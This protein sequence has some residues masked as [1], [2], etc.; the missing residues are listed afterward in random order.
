MRADLHVHCKYSSKSADQVLKK[1]G[2]QESYTEVEEVYRTAKSNGMDLVTITD[3]NAI[4]G[5]LEL[6]RH[7]P[8]DCFLGV[9]ITTCFPE[10]GCAVHV[11]VYDFTEEQFTHMDRIRGDIYELRDYIRR[12]GL[13]YSV[14][15]ATYSVNGKLSLS[16]IEKLILLF[17][18]FET[19]NGTRVATYND[20]L[21]KVLLGL[22]PEKIGELRDRHG[23][24]PFS[25]TPWIKGF[26]GG[27]DEHAGLFIGETFTSG[28]ASTKE[29]FLRALR[30]GRT[31]SG[32]RSNDYRTQVYTFLK[33]AYHF[34]RTKKARGMRQVWN[35]ICGAIFEG[36][37]LNWKTQLKIEHLK[38]SRRGKTRIIASQA[39]R[40]IKRLVQDPPL[41]HREK[42][43]LIYTTVAGFE[44]DLFIANFDGF[45]EAF[46]RADIMK[47]FSSLT[48]AFRA[49]F[50]SLP[51][52]GTFRHLHQS[53]R[54]MDEF[55]QAFLGPRA[56]G[57]KKVLWFTDTFGDLNGVSV[58]LD[59]VVAR[60]AREGIRVRLAVTER[61][62]LSPAPHL[63]GLPTVYE[64]VPEFYPDYC[65]R[66][67]SLLK[68]LERISVEAPSEIIV[69]TPGPV[70]L[71]GL[72]ASRLF[73]IPC[74]G[75]YHS[76][77][78]RMTELSLSGGSFASLVQGYTRWF[79]GAVDEVLVPTHEM[80][81]ALV[82]RGYDR[83]RM[84]IFPRTIDLELFSPVP[85]ER[86]ALRRDWGLEEGMTLLYVGRVS[87]DK[88]LGV[89][90]E[91]YR[92]LVRRGGRVNLVIAGD[93]PMLEELRQ[94]CREEGRVRF[95]GRLKPEELPLLYSFSDILVF[96]STMDTFGMAVLEAQACGLPA[97][98]TNMGGPQEV[99]VA[100]ETG[101]VLPA[102]KPLVWVEEVLRIRRLME[103][104]PAAYEQMRRRAR[105][106]VRSRFSWDRVLRDFFSDPQAKGLSQSGS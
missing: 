40:L 17:D 25:D 76:D 22:T 54:I 32:G 72:L 45:R 78:T 91:M 15:H 56:L 79:Y 34:S 75:I 10:D 95:A 16:T 12:E 92:E 2:T 71:L 5:A 3:H 87:R 81:K 67:P 94:E 44:D 99:I 101:T 23:I 28:E 70:G 77:F 65:L 30:R 41:S 9:E 14:A 4:G 19:I 68:S 86:D 97:L 106:Q 104:E 39:S 48:A 51:F 80:M 33:I 90:L 88:S 38:R 66:F 7:H 73:G 11:L 105:E 93:G 24:D 47:L 84:R 43:D 31:D 6:V 103:K 60:A 58:T 83:E 29:E 20:L 46:V 50:L 69:S 13:P 37:P 18:V 100:G 64:Y 26:T 85:G 96:P 21:K 36:A 53:S 1:F 61:K 59:T 62:D 42:I 63:L 98:V 27:S 82:V 102:G 49:L 57:D 55:R 35:E 8:D 74:R 89:L 52:L